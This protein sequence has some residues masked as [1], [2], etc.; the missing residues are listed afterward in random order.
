MEHVANPSPRPLGRYLLFREI[1]AGGMATVHIGRLNGPAGFARTVA[2][3]QLHP[4]YAK[5]PDFVAMFLDEARLAARIRH[6][7]VVSTLDVVATDGQI[8]LVMDYVQGESLSRLVRAEV[9]S[10]DASNPLIVA[11]VLSGVL[12]GLHAAHE[13]RDERGEA[14]HIVHRD[15]SPQNILVGVDGTPRVVDFGVAKAMGR[16]HTTKDGRLKG[17]L[18][19][20]PPEQLRGRAVTRQTDVYSAAVVLWEALTGRRLISGDTEAE[21]VTAILHGE[22]PPPSDLAPHVPPAFDAVVQRGLERDLDRRYSTALE[23]AL[24]LERC[25]GIASPFEV[26]QWVESRAAEALK[27]RAGLIEEI[28]RSSDGDLHRVHVIVRSQASKGDG[29]HEL[30]TDLSSTAAASVPGTHRRKIAVPTLLGALALVAVAAYAGV[31]A[32]RTRQASQVSSPSEGASTASAPLSELEDS[33]SPSSPTM[34]HAPEKAE[35]PPTATSHGTAA[36]RRP[37]PRGPHVTA[38]PAASSSAQSAPTC[39]A[40]FDDAGRKHWQCD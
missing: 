22:I 24:E 6:P 16:V 8:F 34:T 12:H 27:E 10:Q 11:T 7:N 33:A 15:V 39:R 21:V 1:A 29:S 40:T 4:Q 31:F 30:R 25:V 32:E 14:L 13:A 26:G 17:K 37:P 20:M 38:A 2:I 23:M 19:Y 5:D 3:K 9:L 36:P 28:E 18:A 35:P